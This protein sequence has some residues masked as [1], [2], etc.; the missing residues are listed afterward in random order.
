MREGQESY[1]PPPDVSGREVLLLSALGL[2]QHGKHTHFL[3]VNLLPTVDVQSQVKVN[4]PIYATIV[5]SRYLSVHLQIALLA[6]AII[7]Y[8][9]Y[10]LCIQLCKLIRK[11]IRC[12]RKYCVCLTCFLCG[13]LGSSLVR[14]TAAPAPCI[15]SAV[16]S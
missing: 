15:C 8:F 4:A 11:S 14:Y 13:R 9:D 5:T 2:A 10:G 3:T 6:S 7:F 1:S 16:S 12:S